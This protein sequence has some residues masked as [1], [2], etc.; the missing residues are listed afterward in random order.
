MEIQNMSKLVDYVILY[1][2]AETYYYCIEKNL[3]EI[4]I[5]IHIL[6]LIKD[7]KFNSF[8]FMYNYSSYC[9]IQHEKIDKYI[10]FCKIFL[11]S[12]NKNINEFINFSENFTDIDFD[13]YY[14]KQLSKYNYVLI[15][16]NNIVNESNEK[17]EG[18]VFYDHNSY[19]DYKI[20]SSFK[21]KR[22]NLFYYSRQAYNILEIGFNAG[23]SVFLYLISNPTSKI[24]LFD[25]GDHSY[26]R[27]CFEYLNTEF[28]GRIS[29]IWGDST[30]TV[31]AF[32][33]DIIY[34]F[35]HI[36]GGHT[37]FVAETD[38]YNCKRFADNNS[39][40][41][42]D[43]TNYEP[44]FSLFTD[45]TKYKIAEKLKL[46]FETYTHMLVKYNF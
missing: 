38:F 16:L 21:N 24:Q 41:L 7:K 26:S 28:P 43:D 25:L 36:D 35:I 27:K 13:S 30:K 2:S 6:T 20:S 42:I 15:A 32:K 34:D 4:Y 12:N 19:K 3:K 46:K 23:H 37:R 40:V 33:T 29:I 22:Y 11:K 45:I 14:E 9:F 17:L 31:E 1:T 10:N 18:N 39:L 8:K 44:L 5:P